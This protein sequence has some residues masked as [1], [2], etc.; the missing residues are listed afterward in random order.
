MK[1]WFQI[2]YS[3]QY[4]QFK[5]FTAILWVSKKSTTTLKS[6]ETPDIPRGIKF[7]LVDVFFLNDFQILNGQYD[8]GRCCRVFAPGL[9]A[10]VCVFLQYVF[11]TFACLLF[12]VLLFVLFLLTIFLL[13]C[14]FVCFFLLACFFKFEWCGRHCFCSWF[15]LWVCLSRVCLCL[16]ALLLFVVVFTSCVLFVSFLFCLLYLLFDFLCLFRVF[17]FRFPLDFPNFDCGRY[18]C[19]W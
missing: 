7:W 17:D 12:V 3:S 1:I 13:L 8:T 18:F 15:C 2:S 6:S 19:L 14:F 9:I 4:D 10:R 11:N 5:P 16:R